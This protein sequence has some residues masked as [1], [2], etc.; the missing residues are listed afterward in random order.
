VA[1]KCWAAQWHKRRRS[2]ANVLIVAVK[3]VDL[4]DIGFQ[5]AEE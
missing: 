3:T 5:E 4:K 1:S 2:G